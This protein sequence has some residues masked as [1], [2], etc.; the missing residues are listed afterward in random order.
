MSQG[1]ISPMPG[2]IARGMVK[3]RTCVSREE[4]GG[5]DM[6]M[7]PNGRANSVGAQLAASP[8]RY[9][10]VPF[11]TYREPHRADPHV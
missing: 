4:P 8:E 1:H 2:V 7:K 10:K 9:L 11:K 3:G 5:L 6:A